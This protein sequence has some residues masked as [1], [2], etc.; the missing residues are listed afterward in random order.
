MRAMAV[1]KVYGVNFDGRS[2]RVVASTT[3]AAAARLTGVSP[4]RF[5]QY[6]GETGNAEEIAV[7]MREPGV[8]W[9]RGFAM[10]SEWVRLG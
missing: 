2:R 9:S 3:Q 8:V 1:L 7:A 4:H 6:G 5:R 10:G